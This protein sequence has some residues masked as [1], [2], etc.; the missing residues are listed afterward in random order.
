MEIKSEKT[1]WVV[2]FLR[3][4]MDGLSFVYPSHGVDREIYEAERPTLK[5]TP[6][7]KEPELKLSDTLSLHP[8]A[9][10][11]HALYQKKSLAV[12][13][14][15]GL[16]ADSRSHFD[17]QNLMEQGAE[18][19]S[20]LLQS[21]WIA[22][23]LQ[24]TN[25][26]SKIA[27]VSIGQN[28]PTSL[29]TYDHALITDALRPHHWPVGAK[30]EADFEKALRSLYALD[31]AV[32]PW[33]S[34]WG[35]QTLDTL[36]ELQ[37]IAAIPPESNYPKNEIGGK[38]Q[39]LARLVTE[40]PEIEMATIDMG[41]WDTHKFQGSGVEGTFGNLVGQLSSSLAMFY[42]EV[43]KKRDVVITVQTEFGR[44]L[45][46]NFSRGTDHGHGGVAF[47]I[48]NHVAGGKVL[49]K[50]PGLETGALYQRADLAVTTD[51]R[52]LMAEVLMHSQ[53]FSR[54]SDA[55]PGFKPGKSIGLFS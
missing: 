46:E 54:V 32:K 27:A 48:G 36:D 24:A 33:I 29:F 40:K 30:Y 53:K 38:L 43:S 2:I 21:G 42:E 35:L 8:N 4:G 47:V 5:I 11:M 34:D 13:H 39:T 55:F 10:E 1:L 14:A 28:A 49:G 16:T 6:S 26:P 9:K 50:W 41:G 25:S 23:Y 51:Y 37:A 20:H 19:K 12:I 31:A 45:K 52:S 44:R 7:A 15:I 3:G 17:A 22:R 18:S